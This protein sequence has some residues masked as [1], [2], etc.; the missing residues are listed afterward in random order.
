M[1]ETLLIVEDDPDLLR[2]MEWA[3]RKEGYAVRL[4]RNGREGLDGAFQAP[5]PDLI[6][7][8][9]NLPLVTGTEV[10]RRLRADPRKAIRATVISGYCH[11]GGSSFTT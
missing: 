4:A 7:L 1:P 11:A 5:T 3:F 6:L 10:C 8:D 9:L 2:A